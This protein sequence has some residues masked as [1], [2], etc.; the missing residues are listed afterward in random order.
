MKG[1][2]KRKQKGKS[3]V[4]EETVGEGKEGR[5]SKEH[6]SFEGPY[7]IGKINKEETHRS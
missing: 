2:R 5:Q 1:K 7:F 4:G 6:W 3:G